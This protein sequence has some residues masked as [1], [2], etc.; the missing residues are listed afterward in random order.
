M[1]GV[2]VEWFDARIPHNLFKLL[3]CGQTFLAVNINF[4]RF[5]NEVDALTLITNVEAYTNLANLFIIY[6]IL[7]AN[8]KFDFVPI[9]YYLFIANYL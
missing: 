5:I 6:V 2:F 1:I 9:L 3:C 7:H 4:I 8:S